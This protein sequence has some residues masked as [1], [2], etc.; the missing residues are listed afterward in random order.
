MGCGQS[1]EST[2]IEPLG[3]DYKV[4]KNNNHLGILLGQ[5]LYYRVLESYF[6]KV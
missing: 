3:T 1:S 5:F 4:K 2:A 6:I